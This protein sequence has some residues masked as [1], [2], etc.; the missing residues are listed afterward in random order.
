M[1]PEELIGLTRTLGDPSLDLALLAEGNTSTL[2]AEEGSFWVKASGQS[3][4]S[5]AEDGF[6]RCRL[7]P[8]VAALDGSLSDAEVRQ[9]LAESMAEGAGK[10]SVEAF[11]HAWLLTLPG[12]DWVGHTHP[13]SLLPLLCRAD[14]RELAKRRLFPD[15]VVCCGPAACFVPYVDPGLPLAVKIRE[16]VQ[17]YIVKWEE[18]PKTIWLANHGLIALGATPAEVMSATL[19]SAKAGRVWTSLLSTMVKDDLMLE[20]MSSA[21]VARIRTRPDEHYRQKLLRE[22]G[23]SAARK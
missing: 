8:L 17:A 16:E 10:P 22:A 18:V 21:S 6:V 4:G 19:M 1:A 20:P 11:M 5:I 2:A 14:A 3:M 12:V 23:I 7:E 9:V 15:E 13:A